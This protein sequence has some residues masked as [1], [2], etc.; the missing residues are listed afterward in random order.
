M[1]VLLRLDYGVVTKVA[2]VMAG[3][4]LNAGE[5]P[6]DWITGVHPADSAA[7]LGSLAGTK[8]HLTDE[9]LAVLS[10]QATPKATAELYSLTSPA[11]R[12]WLRDISDPAAVQELI[13]LAKT[14]AD[15]EVRG[16]AIFWL[17]QK[18]GANATATLIL[19]L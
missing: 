12:L 19:Q 4:R 2:A 16:Q 14:D 7:Y 13:G 17:G 11:H 3:C 1:Y 6:F 15:P 18:A 9:A 5:L 8:G 10:M